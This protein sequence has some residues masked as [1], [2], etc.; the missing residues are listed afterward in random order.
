MHRNTFLLVV[1]LAIF[2][3]LVVGVNIGRR[4]AAPSPAQP[5]PTPSASLPATPST[6]L[7]TYRNP[8]CGITLTYPSTLNLMDSASGSALFIDKTNANE[9]VVITCQKEIPRPPL[10]APKIETV[11]LTSDNSNAS[12]SA[13]LYHDAS[14]KD[15]TSIDELIFR[16]P[17]TG[18]D[19]FIAGFGETFNAIIK[20]VK[21]TP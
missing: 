18:L 16:H 21:L 19:V 7:N 17:T 2:A 3:A 20:T 6:S 11:I 14:A 12:V 9:S 15:G 13:K 4:L 1:F 5:T 10:V 8:V